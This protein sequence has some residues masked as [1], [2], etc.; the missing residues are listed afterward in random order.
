[1]SAESDELFRKAGEAI[2]AHPW[3]R[4]SEVRLVAPSEYA[5]VRSASTSDPI[6]PAKVVDIPAA[7]KAEWGRAALKALM[8][9]ER[10]GIF[11]CGPCPFYRE[12]RCR[13]HLGNDDTPGPDCPMHKEAKP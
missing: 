2:A 9:I 4:E 12:G 11:P 8:W 3:F 6:G 7:V 5:P 13:L 1:M 10:E